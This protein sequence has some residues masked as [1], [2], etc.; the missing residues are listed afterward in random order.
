MTSDQQAAA[1]AFTA[2]LVLVQVLWL[3]F[4]LVAG[5]FLKID[6]L[7]D[8]EPSRFATQVFLVGYG[9]PAWMRWNQWI[10]LYVVV[11]AGA[12]GFVTIKGNAE[13]ESRW[14]AFLLWLPA[15][16]WAAVAVPACVFNFIAWICTRYPQSLHHGVTAI[17]ELPVALIGIAYLFSCTLALSSARQVGNL[18]LR[19]RERSLT[20]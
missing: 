11:A 19:S 3:I 2:M 7:L 16:P 6:L 10:T 18:W 8:G 12:L 4:V 15:M 5:N 13:T 1:I 14:W 9:L 20:A 17:H